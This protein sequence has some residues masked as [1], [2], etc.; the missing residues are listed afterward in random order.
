[1][2]DE[3]NHQRR[4]LRSLLYNR[5]HRHHHHRPKLEQ[6]FYSLL[7]ELSN[8]TQLLLDLRHTWQLD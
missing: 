1:M 4:Q 7:M 8:Y 5:E 2:F 6:I 3:Y